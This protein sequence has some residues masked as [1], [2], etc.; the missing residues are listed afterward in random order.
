MYIEDYFKSVTLIKDITLNNILLEKG[1]K[2]FKGSD[3]FNDW[4]IILVSYFDEKSFTRRFVALPRKELNITYI[5][6]N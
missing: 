5:L 3:I 1:K 6:S 4:R 2:L